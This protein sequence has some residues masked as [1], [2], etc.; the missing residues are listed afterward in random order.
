MRCTNC[1]A[2]DFEGAG[3]DC[4]GY[5]MIACRT[6]DQ[7]YAFRSVWVPVPETALACGEGED[8]TTISG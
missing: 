7:V 4:G 1:G 3:D 5:P 6:C 2:A 8:D